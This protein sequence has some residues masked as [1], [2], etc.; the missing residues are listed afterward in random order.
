MSFKFEKLIVWQKAID[1]SA[2]VDLLT[3]TF[4]R[5]ELYVLTSQIKRAADSIALNIA[6]GSTGQSNPEFNKFLGYALRS[7]IEVVSCLYLGSRRNII[8]QDNFDK[9]YNQCKE[10]LSMINALRYSLK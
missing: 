9:I 2:D 1:L 8:D 6:E 4:P 5:E 7:T 3:K 10:I